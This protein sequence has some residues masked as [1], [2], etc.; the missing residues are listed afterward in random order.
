[1]SF[2]GACHQLLVYPWE[3]R[4]PFLEDTDFVSTA[5]N[6]PRVSESA[7]V[8]NKQEL[9]L[10]LGLV[11]L[12]TSECYPSSSVLP[13]AYRKIALPIFDGG[14]QLQYSRTVVLN[15]FWPTDDLLKK[16]PMD[17]FD[18]MTNHEQQIENIAHR[19]ENSRACS[20]LVRNEGPVDH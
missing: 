15:L 10:V 1:V 12:I 4:T 18:M 9:A 11:R 5:V 6:W 2:D 19:S 20:I 14:F 7:V 3:T 8:Q 13:L 17:H 16:Y